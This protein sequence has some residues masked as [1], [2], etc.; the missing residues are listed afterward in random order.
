MLTNQCRQRVTHADQEFID[1]TCS[2]LW[3]SLFNQFD[4]TFDFDTD[5]ASKA[6]NAAVGAL[7]S[8]LEREL[9]IDC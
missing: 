5:M 2:D 1:A 4:D 3:I 6:A 9:A 8:Y 7:R